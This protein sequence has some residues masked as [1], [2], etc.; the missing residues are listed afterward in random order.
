MDAE[1]HVV[2]NLGAILVHSS[3]HL[4]GSMS[5]PAPAFSAL[6]ERIS[7]RLIGEHTAG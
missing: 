3:V 4:I 6:P 5:G 7:A 2:Q 1:E